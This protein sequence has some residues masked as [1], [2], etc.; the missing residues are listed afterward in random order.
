MNEQLSSRDHLLMALRFYEIDI[1]RDQGKYLDL[2]NEYQ[3]E[4]ENGFLFKLLWQGKVI[5]PFT[6]LD[7]MCQFIKNS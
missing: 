2:E 5:A 3:V 1:I 4:I 7:E 6:D